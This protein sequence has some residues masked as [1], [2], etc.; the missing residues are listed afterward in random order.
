MLNLHLGC[1]SNYIKGWVNIDLNKG[2][3]KYDLRKPL[4]YKNNTVNFI[5]NEA[6]Y[7]HLNYLEQISFLKDCYRVLAPNGV[8]RTACPDLDFCV[9]LYLNK[10]FLKEPWTQSVGTYCHTNCQA[11][12]AAFYLWGHKYI[13]DYEDYTMKLKGAG[14]SNYYRCE[15][16]KSS[17]DILNNLETRDTSQDSLIVEAVK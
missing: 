7:E 13:P 17:Y 10:E 6:F 15:F 11:L 3:V 16:K 12:N 2:D 8:L 4:P 5:F 9:K 1:G 14:F